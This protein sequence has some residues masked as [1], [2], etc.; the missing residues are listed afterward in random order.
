MIIRAI[1]VPNCGNGSI[2]PSPT[3][4]NLPF[5]G[6]TGHGRLVSMAMLRPRLLEQRSASRLASRPPAAAGDV[7]T[8]G[9]LSTTT[10]SFYELLGIPVSGSHDDIKRAYKQLARKYHPDVSPPDRTEEYT[11]RFILVQE[12]YETLS[13]PEC[14]A[15]YDRYLARGLHYALSARRRFGEELEEKSGWKNRWQDQLVELKRRSTTRN[16][17]DNLSWGARMRKRWAESLAD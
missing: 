9:E 17:E 15:L 11:Q 10:E 4:T 14:R 3:T 13:D 8:I 1:M 5:A 2:C 16:S 12:A 7:G 6:S